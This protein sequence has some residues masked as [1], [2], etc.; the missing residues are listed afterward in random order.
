MVFNASY[1]GNEHGDPD[2]LAFLAE[3]NLYRIEWHLLNENLYMGT[4]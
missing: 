3:V 1:L 2:I 4:F